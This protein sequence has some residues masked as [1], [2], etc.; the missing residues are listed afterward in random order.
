VLVA[1][2]QGYQPLLLAAIRFR[3]AVWW[4]VV[5]LVAFSPSE[6]RWADFYPIR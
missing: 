6:R 2:T 1:H 5:L 3:V 4:S